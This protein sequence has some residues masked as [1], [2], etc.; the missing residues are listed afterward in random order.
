M[1]S[2]VSVVQSPIFIGT[3]VFLGMV[4]LIRILLSRDP[5]LKRHYGADRRL[6]KGN[7]P[8]IPFY[9]SD[10]IKV[11]EDRRVLPDRRRH[12]LLAMQE[13]MR[14]DKITG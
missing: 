14:E 4:S 10:G 11:T 3:L 12:R 8:E 13:G 6:H 7:M 2:V 1:D 9:D 5:S